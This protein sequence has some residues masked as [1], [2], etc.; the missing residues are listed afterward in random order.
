MKNN[1]RIGGLSAE[2][3]VS[4]IVTADTPDIQS[5]EVHGGRVI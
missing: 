3:A 5:A 1:T 4:P 2:V